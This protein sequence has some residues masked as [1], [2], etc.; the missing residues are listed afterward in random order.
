VKQYQSKEYLG[1]RNA[2][3]STHM[4]QIKP[5]PP[6]ISADECIRLY[7]QACDTLYL[8]FFLHKYERRLNERVR[9]F[10]RT[11]G[12]LHRF[13]D[14]KQTIVLTLLELVPKFEPERNVPFE[15]YAKDFVEAAVDKFIR[16]NGSFYT[17][18][19]DNHYRALK[20]ITAIYYERTDLSVNERIAEITR[21]TGKSGKRVVEFLLEGLDFKGYQS[22]LKPCYDEHGN[23]FETDVAALDEYSNPETVVPLLLCYDDLVAAVDR[24]DYAESDI[25]HKLLGIACMN[26]GRVCAKMKKSEIA[27]LYEYYDTGFV[28]RTMDSALVSIIRDLCLARWMYAMRITQKSGKTQNG[29]LLSIAYTYEPMLNGDVGELEF[30]LT[31]PAEKGYVI[32]R[33]SK[34]DRQYP[35]FRRLASEVSKMQKR[36]EFVKSKVVVWEN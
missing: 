12:Q 2:R 4:Y 5:A 20:Q 22:R 18:E 13:E 11:Y 1:G 7:Q 25:L 28:D 9:Y 36:G 33:F 21:Q 23:Y 15:A 3:F 26:C 17:I 16:Q 19:N 34:W 32:D 30:D 24:L 14:I 6:D 8:R 35:F 10:G 29:K 31:Q 27:N